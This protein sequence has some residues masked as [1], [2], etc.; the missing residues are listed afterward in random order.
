M[1]EVRTALPIFPIYRWIRLSSVWSTKNPA[2]PL[3]NRPLSVQN[4]HIGLGKLFAKLQQG[5]VENQQV[6]TIARLRAD[7]E[8]AYGD[9]LKGIAPAAERPDGFA[10][11][12][13]ASTR[14][15]YEGIKKEMDSVRCDILHFNLA[16]MATHLQ[17]LAFWSS[18]ASLS[19]VV[20]F[21]VFLN[22]RQHHQ[23]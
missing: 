18:I 10:R 14:K 22:S 8:D 23:I 17:H 4:A 12:E 9:K 16:I 11:D 13:G 7:A 6:I 20:E 15:A 3:S 21:M 19:L 2:D 5:V 1:L